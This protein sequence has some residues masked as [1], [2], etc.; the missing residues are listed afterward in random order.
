MAISICILQMKIGGTWE[1]Q[2]LSP[3][4]MAN[5]Q[6]SQGWNL[7]IYYTRNISDIHEDHGIIICKLYEQQY[8]AYMS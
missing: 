2:A 5:K 1:D 3:G 8:F 4:Q 6:K 7:S